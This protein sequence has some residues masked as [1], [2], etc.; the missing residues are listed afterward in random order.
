MYKINEEHLKKIKFYK[1]IREF[2]ILAI[3]LI[4]LSFL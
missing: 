3:V 1:I 2:Y 4:L